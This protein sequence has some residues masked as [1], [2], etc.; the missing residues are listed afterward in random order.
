[1]ARKSKK[2]LQREMAEEM[3]RCLN[4]AYQSDPDAIV[5]LI[6]NRVPCN[7]ALEKDPHVMV[8]DSLVSNR[9]LV[10][11]M[12]L[13]NGVLQAAGLPRIAMQSRNRK[14]IGFILFPKD[15]K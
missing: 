7:E 13:L 1:M 2:Q 4:R 6:N 8:A 5:A 10:G 12:G 11:P 9:S 15:L 14:M 3:I